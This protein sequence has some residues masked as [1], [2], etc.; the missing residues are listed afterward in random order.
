MALLIIPHKI[1]A[2]LRPYLR[3]YARTLLSKP[4]QP[5]SSRPAGGAQK[6]RRGR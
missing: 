1:S 5:T 2:N 3:K 6:I 4:K